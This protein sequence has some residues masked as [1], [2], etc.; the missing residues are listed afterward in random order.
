MKTANAILLRLVAFQTNLL[1]AH[2]QADTLG[3]THKALGDLYA[4]VSEKLDELAEVSMGKDNNR[5]FPEESFEIVPNMPVADLLGFGIGTLASFRA[6]CTPGE[7]DDMLNLAA[8][9]ASAINHA[10]YF[11]RI[12]PVTQ[13]A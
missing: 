4:T 10:R 12:A 8:D 11:L 13:R 9:I 5:D 3:N 7:D 6:I 1:L 2:W